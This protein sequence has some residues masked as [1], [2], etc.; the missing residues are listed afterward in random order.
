MPLNLAEF[1]AADKD[2]ARLRA[3]IAAGTCTDRRPLAAE[4]ALVALLTNRWNA[5]LSGWLTAA[6]A[7]Q[8]AAGLD[9]DGTTAVA[10]VE[11]L[12]DGR[13]YL[14]YSGGCHGQHRLALAVTGPV[15]ARLHWDAYLSSCAR[16][17][18]VS[19]VG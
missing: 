19:G 15:L 9:P 3:S 11:T 13:P 10:S 5:G 6:E 2:L 7:H 17:R 8:L 12:D 18:R 14:I 16:R 1:L 4:S